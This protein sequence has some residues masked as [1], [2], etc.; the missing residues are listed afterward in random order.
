MPASARRA[1]EF[2]A[3]RI[4]DVVVPFVL[5][6]PRDRLGSDQIGAPRQQVPAEH[7]HPDVLT[8]KQLHHGPEVVGVKLEFQPRR[9]QLISQHLLSVYQSLP[10]Q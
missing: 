8:A 6:Q 1:L 5:R 3:Q 10:I 2:I 9:Q 7:L 4:D